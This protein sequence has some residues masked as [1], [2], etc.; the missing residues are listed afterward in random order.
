MCY[1]SAVVTETVAAKLENL[2]ASPG[3]YLFLDSQGR[4]LYVGKATRL[5]AR[6]RQYFQPATSDTRPM[7]PLLLQSIADIETI[8]TASEKEALILE[9]SLI[10]KHRPKFNVKLRDDKTYPSLRMDLSS[11]FPR[12]ELVRRPEPDG[13]RYFGPHHSAS[14]ARR[15]LHFINKHFQL[16][17]CSDSVLSSRK[18]PCLQYHIKRCPGPCVVDVDRELYEQNVRAVILLLEGR[19]DEVFAQMRTRMQQASQAMEYELA[20][21]LRD[22]L[23]AIESVR[24]SQRVVAVSRID[25]DVLGLYRD[26]EVCELAVIFVRRGRVVDTTSFA[27]RKVGVADEEVI[28]AFLRDYYG[29][30]GPAAAAIPDEV[31]VPML[32]ESPRGV[33]DWLSERRGRKTLLLHPKRGARAS[34]LALA[35]DNAAHA[36]AQKRNSEGDMQERLA[37]MQRRLR[38]SQLPRVIECVDISHQS[39]QDTAAGLVRMVDGVLDKSGYRSYH[40]KTANP[41]DDYAAMFEVL[42]RRFRRAVQAGANDE[43]AERSWERPDLLVVDGGRGQLGVAQ[44]AAAD[45]GVHGL[46][47]VALA[48]E[49]EDAFGN[50]QGDRV[51][52]PG[53]KNGI[54]IKAHT[55][56]VLLARLRDEAHRFANEARRK[57][58]ATRQLHSELAKIEG[59]GAVTRK[60]LLSRIGG[61]QQICQ[62][63]DET[64]RSEVGLTVKQLAALRKHYAYGAR[65]AHG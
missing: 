35:N 22:Q 7:L 53:Q 40:V 41:G 18:R 44:A 1:A 32:P 56:L 20:A 51:F 25:Q 16:R 13:A 62:A 31:I 52:L 15:T 57:R 60:R 55:S 21:L 65:G 12:I 11:P 45:L 24:E 38:L 5:R 36:Y 27:M 10:K 61:P 37:D 33:Q 26:A 64:L 54:A 19:H 29:S 50:L 3:C 28:G 46:A 23:Q 8:V 43:A 59:I 39:G 2:P 6:V 42:S 4:V 34:L 14:S 58:G 49:R 47:I 30:Q 17:S 63:S 48:E 9:D